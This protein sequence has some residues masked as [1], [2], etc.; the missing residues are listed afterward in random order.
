MNQRALRVLYRVL[1]AAGLNP[2]RAAADVPDTWLVQLTEGAEALQ[3]GRAL[4][5]GCGAGRNALYLASH[6]WDA[7]GIDMVGR[8]IDN[9]SSPAVGAAASAPFIH[10]DATRLA[11]LGIATAAASS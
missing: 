9:A 10:G 4:D 2:A 5:L 1:T 8:V 11:D 6:S 3:P 7:V